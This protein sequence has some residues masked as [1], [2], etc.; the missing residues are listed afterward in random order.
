MGSFVNDRRNPN[1]DR[2]A[3]APASRRHYVV[4]LLAAEVRKYLCR[5]VELGV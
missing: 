2:R 5:F 3:P 4:A 1:L